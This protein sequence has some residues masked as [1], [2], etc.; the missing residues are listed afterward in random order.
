MFAANTDLSCFYSAY[1]ADDSLVEIVPSFDF[2][3]K[4]P[5][6]SSSPI[7]PFKAGITRRVPL[8]F[9]LNLHQRS[10][11]TIATPVWL[12]ASNL[13]E[14]IAYEKKENPLWNDN[15]RLPPQYYEIAKRL[16][17]ALDDRSL[18]LLIQ[19]LLEVRL[20]KLRQ[21]F[22]ELMKERGSSDPDFIV[23]VSGIGTQ[24]LAVL[25][26]F[27][28]Q[29]LNDQRYLSKANEEADAE[30]EE[31]GTKKAPAALRSRVPVRRFR[32]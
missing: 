22:Q 21:Q 23:D 30:T 19:D 12:N 16:S 6:L 5:L 7:G 2:D 20:D 31:E 10:L 25:K 29:A 1:I 26:A 15:S 17:S 4:L 11:C 8:W 13:S 9:A 27:V 32:S 3:G 18:P 28:Q 14:I 24:E